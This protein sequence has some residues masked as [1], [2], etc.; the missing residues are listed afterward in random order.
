MSMVTNIDKT[1]G[2]KGKKG[3]ELPGVKASVKVRAGGGV[4]AVPLHAGVACLMLCCCVCQRFCK[5]LR[6]GGN[7]PSSRAGGQRPR[8]DGQCHSKA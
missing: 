7:R 5:F 6:N 8:G 3:D 4:G 1:K 2:K